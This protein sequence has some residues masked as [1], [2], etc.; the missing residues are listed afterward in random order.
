MWEKPRS[1]AD[2][3]HPIV[4]QAAEWSWRLL[5][6]LAAAI[7][8]AMLVARLSTVLI[9]MSI[10]LLAAA[11]LAPLVDWMQ[12][13]GV[14]RWIGVVVALIGSLGLVAGTMTFVVEQFVAGVPQLSDEATASI[15]K[16]QDWLINGPPHLSDE[17]IRSAGDTLVRTIEHNQDSV[18][19]GALTTATMIGQLLTGSFLTLFIL[20]FF[21]HG[22]AQIWEFVTRVVPTEHR[23]RVRVAGA[24]GFGTLVGF[25]RATVVVA[26]VDA[27]GIGSGLLILGVPLALP[28]AS[29]V[30]IS[31]FIPI[32][33]AFFA[34]FVAVFVA[35]VTEGL[36]T[37]LI[38][39]G[40][41]IAV[42]QLESHVLQPLLLGRAVSVHPLAVVVAIAS[43][44]VLGGIAGA[45]LAVPFVAVMNTAIRSLLGAPEE[46]V[47]D[48]V[49]GGPGVH[50]TQPD[51]PDVPGGERL[52]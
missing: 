36:V 52:R 14:P 51:E 10:A 43:G 15:H 30:F 22:G 13:L 41:I 33:G 39:L 9:P 12:R 42:M 11:L 37:A 16:I 29:L 32:I 50:A 31:A 21:L 5:V 49:T 24:L 8:V 44:L 38:V 1:A 28:L 27:I 20:V 40:I 6:I 46:V 3:V 26:A 47:H 34:G 48:L 45:L 19:S 17:Q 18:T 2:S 4:R 23:E 25:V 35:L 7:A